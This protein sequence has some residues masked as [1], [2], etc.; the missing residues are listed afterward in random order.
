MSALPEVEWQDKAACRG[1]QAGVFFP[2]TTTESRNEKLERERRAKAICRQ[3]SVIDDCLSHALATGEQHG[4]WGGANEIERRS[5][6]FRLGSNG[7]GR[8]GA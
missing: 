6:L 8:P 1:P 2:P 7:F 4:V 3:C 5:M